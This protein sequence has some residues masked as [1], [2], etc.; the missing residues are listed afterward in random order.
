MRFFSS[1][2]LASAEKLTLAN[3]CS[4]AETMV[5][6]PERPSCSG[7]RALIGRI[8]YR[9]MET[10]HALRKAAPPSPRPFDLRSAAC[11]GG[12]WRR[13]DLDRSARFLNRCNCGLG[14]AMDGKLQRHLDFTPA[15]QTDTIL[16]APQHPAPDQSLNVESFPGI[17]RPA[18]D[19]RLDAVEVHHIELKS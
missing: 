7:Y 13:Q 18:I 12:L 16:G 19:R 14:C 8:I 1:S 3:N 10:P 9:K 4:A 6:A 17:E 5:L 11:G 2:A 15:E